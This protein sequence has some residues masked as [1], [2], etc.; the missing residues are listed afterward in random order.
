MQDTGDRTWTPIPPWMAP[1]HL[2]TGTLTGVWLHPNESVDWH[3]MVMPDGSLHVYGYSIT[4]HPETYP[5]RARGP[6]DG[7]RPSK[8]PHAGSSPAGRIGF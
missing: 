2:Q 4:V 7:Q 8:P 3:T 1:K 5:A 6:K